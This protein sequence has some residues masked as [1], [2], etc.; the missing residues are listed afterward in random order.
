MQ[1]K[2]GMRSSL[3]GALQGALL[4]TG[5]WGSVACNKTDAPKVTDKPA[6]NKHGLS[7]EQAKQALVVVGDETIT[8]G[9]FA[10]QLADKSPYLR[11]RYTSPERR[12]ELLDELVR[13]ELL[14]RE[15][16]RRG[17]DATDEVV[18]T[19]KQVM[20]QQ[21][22]KAEFEDKVKL[23]DIT[24][25]EI[26][27]Y[28][29]GHPQEFNK[30]AQVRASEIVVKDEAKAK[31]ALKQV[32]D[33]KDDNKLFRDLAAANE[34]PES[35]QR[36]GDLQF[37]SLPAQRVE[38]D[39]PVPDAVATAAFTLKDVGDIYPQLVKSDLGFHIVKLTGRRKE[40]A[41]TLDQ[42]R[43][44]I[45]HKLWREK[46]EAMVETFVKSLRDQARVE[47]NDALLAQLKV[48]FPAAPTGVAPGPLKGKD[49][50]PAKPAAAAKE[51]TPTP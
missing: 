32:L 24:D 40:L 1:G 42:A 17:L 39:P 43:R 10:E 46:R 45:Q 28:Y 11:A 51:S 2:M 14:A 19:K 26:E 20:I 3:R 36:F 18:N 15:A 25:A 50:K 23:S 49:S 30:P 37:F 7:A 33:A 27:A 5:L 41:R 22:M 4:L 31:K 48:E 6:A 44:P 13:F 9:D 47:Q 16:K 35:A 21:M 34:N 12:R 38:G 8:V 29:N